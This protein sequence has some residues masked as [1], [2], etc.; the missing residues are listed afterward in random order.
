MASSSESTTVAGWLAFLLY[1]DLCDLYLDLCD[2]TPEDLA[3]VTG[4]GRSG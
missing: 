3:G 4:D 1:L 2:V